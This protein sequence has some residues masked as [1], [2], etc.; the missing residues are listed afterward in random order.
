[1]TLITIL[2][3]IAITTMIYLSIILTKFLDDF[4]KSK[5]ESNSAEFLKTY[6]KHANNILY[7]VVDEA[8]DRVAKDGLTEKEYCN[9]L[10]I[11][12]KK[13]FEAIMGKEVRYVIEHMLS[14]DEWL[15]L[16]INRGK[17]IY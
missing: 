14:Y 12:T 13:K 4:I 7:D 1:M 15:L 17:R 5:A 9:K 6:F 2:I 16:A 3:V 10:L 11:Y 8:Y